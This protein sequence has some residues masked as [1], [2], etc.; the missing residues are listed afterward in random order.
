[1]ESEFP[2]NKGCR[3][4]GELR[5]NL[6]RTIL[7]QLYGLAVIIAHHLPVTPAATE[8]GLHCVL[9]RHTHIQALLAHEETMTLLILQAGPDRLQSLLL[10][11]P[12]KRVQLVW[13]EIPVID[14]ITSLL[15]TLS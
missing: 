9:K 8:S 4:S 12:D 11:A 14:E 1:H 13:L 15:I 6:A 7:Y 3:A 2:G 5:L 10:P